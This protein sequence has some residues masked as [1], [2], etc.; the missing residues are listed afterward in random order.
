ML[1]SSLS[2]LTPLI[3]SLLICYIACSEITDVTVNSFANNVLI[4]YIFC[5]EFT[6]NGNICA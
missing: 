1:G 3:H 6:E 4:L 5:M 2:D